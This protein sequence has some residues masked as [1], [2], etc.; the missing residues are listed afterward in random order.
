[1]LPLRQIL[2][3][4]DFSPSA[5]AAL[6]CAAELASRFDARIQLLH[7]LPTVAQ[8]VPFPEVAP[9]PTG[10]LESLSL[11]AHA[12]LGREARRVD[13]AKVTTELREGSIVDAILEGAA[14][15]KSDLIVMGTHGRRGLSHALLGSVAERVV[16]LSPV[17]VLT[18]RARDAG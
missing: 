7:V 2:V 5:A 4:T 11:Q 8:F 1:M 13:R 16:R 12:Q 15:S 17:P 18:V 6:E 3:P 10:W 9:L 14:A